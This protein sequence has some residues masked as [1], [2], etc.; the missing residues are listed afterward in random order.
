MI[1]KGPMR[2][3]SLGKEHV[4]CQQVVH[5]PLAEVTAHRPLKH[6]VHHVL[7]RLEACAAQGKCLARLEHDPGHVRGA[8]GQPHWHHACAMMA[9]G[10]G[11]ARDLDTVGQVLLAMRGVVVV[12][13]G[14][15]HTVDL[16]A[17]LQRVGR[18]C[19]AVARWRCRRVLLPTL[20]VQA[21]C[22]DGKVSMHLSGRD[23]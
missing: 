5:A 1:R 13:H 19:I 22:V 16:T 21:Q 23:P 17:Q 14:G 2:P 20:V 10:R 4:A 6:H 3:A 15:G 9:V 18:A 12:A 11:P 7:L 8:V